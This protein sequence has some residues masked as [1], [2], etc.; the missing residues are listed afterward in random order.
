[1]LTRRL[2]LAAGAALLARAGAATSPER[3]TIAT[4]YPA[5]A[6][7]GEGIAFFSA[8]AS[9]TSDGALQVQPLFDAPNGLRSATMLD[10]VSKG[11]V[12]AADAFTGALGEAAPIFQLSA[13]PFLTLSAADAARLLEIAR[14]AYRAALA[15]RGL[16]LLYATPWPPTGL[17]S[18]APIPDLAALQDLRVR[19]YDAASTAVL[20]AA[21]AKPLLLSFADTL[22]RVRAGEVDAV[23]SSGDGGAGARLWDMLRFFTTLDYAF[24]LSLAFCSERTFAAL[25]PPVAAG[26]Q[27]AARETE[28]RQFQAMS[29]R[30]SENEARMRQNGVAIAEAPSLRAAL[31]RAGEPVVAAW[32]QKAGA[33]GQ[34]ILNEYRVGRT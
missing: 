32:T 26:V 23:L 28:M 30:V 34:A 19:T 3:W 24:P 12:T 6:I 5:S 20:K 14:P 10:S 25:P 15:A 2:T 29:T 18:R 17:W 33:D 4:E 7:S 13:L 11:T 8:T 27:Q 31:A 21:G 16:A 9:A 1:M 22:P